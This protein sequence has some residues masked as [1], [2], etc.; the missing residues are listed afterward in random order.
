[1]QKILAFLF[2][3]LFSTTIM[4]AQVNPF[5]ENFRVGFGAGVNFS[6]IMETQSY[7]LYEDLTGEEYR[8]TYSSIFQNFGHQYFVQLDY[9]LMD[10]LALTLK[11]G[12]YT[13]SFT[14]LTNIVFQDETVEQA[15]EI[16]LRYFEIP[17]EVRYTA[18]LGTFMPYAGG[19]FTY[20]HL[21]GSQEATNQTFIRPK[22]TLGGAVGTYIDLNYL[23]LDFNVGYHYG[24]HVITSKANR[25]DT[26]SRD[27]YSQS[28]IRLNDLSI[29]LSVLFS[30]QKKSG[31][32]RKVK[33]KFPQ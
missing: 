20:A 33:C 7:N 29:N 31:R 28:D 5:L 15:N 17:L 4:T 25:D 27:S 8:N 30:L 9:R 22:M 26:G 1:M 23:I 13:Y 11:P 16:R 32:G 19:G 14:R 10:F 21:M 3:L 24:L 6:H 18:D 12:T 2:V